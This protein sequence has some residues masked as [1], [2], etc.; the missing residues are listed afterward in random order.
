MAG[1]DNSFAYLTVI[2]ND[3]FNVVYSFYKSCQEGRR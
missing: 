3:L 2:L 1:D